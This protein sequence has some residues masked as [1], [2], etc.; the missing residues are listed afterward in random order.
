MIYQKGAQAGGQRLNGRAGCTCDLPLF[1]LAQ[2]GDAEQRGPKRALGRIALPAR[3]ALKMNG[4]RPRSG[5]LAFARVT[6]EIP[7]AERGT[8]FDR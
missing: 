7:G 1:V 5:G 4:V 6:A 2:L 8:W 3:A